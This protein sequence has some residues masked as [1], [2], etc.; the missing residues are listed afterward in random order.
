MTLKHNTSQVLF[1]YCIETVCNFPH[2]EG[3]FRSIFVWQILEFKQY[4]VLNNLAY[5]G[6]HTRLLGAFVSASTDMCLGRLQAAQ[7]QFLSQS[8]VETEQLR[9]YSSSHKAALKQN[10][11]AVTVPLTKRRWNSTAA[12]FG[13]VIPYTDRIK[14]YGVM[15]ICPQSQYYSGRYLERQPTAGFET[16]TPG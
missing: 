8:G 14:L 6:A 10:S 13:D 12:Q 5:A 9:C 4:V 11:C 7:L 3:S 16:R 2:V 1:K 15:N